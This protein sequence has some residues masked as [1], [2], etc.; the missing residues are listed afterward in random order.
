VRNGD[1]TAVSALVEVEFETMY[2]VSHVAKSRLF[3]TALFGGTNGYWRAGVLKSIRFR[4]DRLTEDIDA[5]L[6]TLLAGY[7]IVHDRSIVSTEIEPETLADLWY[8]RK[9]WAQGWFQCAVAYQWALLKC[10]YLGLLQRFFWTYLLSWRVIY[11]A[12]SHFLLP[13]LLV[14]WLHIGRVAV[15]MNAYIWF[16][17]IITLTSGPFETVAAYKNRAF[18]QT[19]GRRYLFYALTAFPYTMF[20]NVIQMVA[21]RDEL[22]G[23]REWIVSRRAAR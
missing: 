7:R 23:K 16:A 12:L 14:F 19:R 21:I 22:L 11:D 17:L 10:K 6:R 20:K 9:R 15:P 5:T 4:T 1:R 18:R 3:K 13:I 2:G 8:Q